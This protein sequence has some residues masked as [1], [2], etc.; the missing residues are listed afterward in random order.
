MKI[1]TYIKKGSKVLVSSPHE[2][3]H[4][5]DG[6]IKIPEINMHII[7]EYLIKNDLCSCI[8]MEENNEEDDV[9]Y[10]KD[11]E[12]KQKIKKICEKN[13][14]R[15]IIDIHGLSKEREQRI[16]VCTNKMANC[17]FYLMQ[18]VVNVFSKNK[19]GE[20]SIGSPF[21]NIYENCIPTY[22]KRELGIDSIGIEVNSKLFNGDVQEKKL[23]ECF[24]DIVSEER[25]E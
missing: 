11:N 17:G 20:I 16:N 25:K 1:G 8:W 10:T 22:C 24:R 4:R 23:L 21:D 12:Y 9:T 5:R 19:M 6:K 15:A 3:E 7:R 13:D 2:I 18:K 14:I